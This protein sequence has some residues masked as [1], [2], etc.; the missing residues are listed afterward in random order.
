[1]SWGKMAVISSKE[2]TITIPSP[3]TFIKLKSSSNGPCSKKWT[4]SRDRYHR[5][6][7][8]LPVYAAGG[9]LEEQNSSWSDLLTPNSRSYDN[10]TRHYPVAVKKELLS[11]FAKLP[12]TTLKE[13]AMAIVR[14]NNIASGKSLDRLGMVGAS[15]LQSLDI[16]KPPENPTFVVERPAAAAETLQETNEHKRMTGFLFQYA[17]SLYGRLAASATW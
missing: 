15:A 2:S 8:V 3:K 7:C 5:E 17:K 12:E 11:W 16:N 4:C 13:R 14:R 1:M 6:C 10:G 9:F